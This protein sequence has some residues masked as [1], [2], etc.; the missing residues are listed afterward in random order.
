MT[1]DYESIAARLLANS[2]AEHFAGYDPFDSLNSALFRRTPLARSAFARLAWLQLGKR[3][4][5][6]LRPALLVPKVRN[7][8][9]IALFILG[10]CEDHQRTGEEAFL[11]EAVALGRWLVTHRSDPGVW[12][13]SCW[14]YPFD[15]QAR[16]FFVP[17]GKPNVIATVYIARALYRLA[18]LT[19][20]EE[21][22]RHAL[23]SASFI[24]RRL[25]VDDATRPYIAYVPGETAFVHNA[26]LW[27]AA[28]CTFAG[29]RLGN[30]NLVD[31][32]LRVAHSSAADQRAD[33][34]W[35]YGSRSHHRFI[36]GFHTGFNI[37]ALKIIC[38]ETAD[39]ELA[40]ACDA[41]YKFYIQCCFDAA[42]TAKYYAHET[43]PV[44][45]HSVAQ[46]IVT[47]IKIDCSLSGLAACRRILDRGMELLYRPSVGL[48]AY[49]RGR[50]VRNNVS[51]SR[52]TQ[53]WAYYSLALFN[54]HSAAGVTSNEG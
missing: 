15:W 32:G 51:Y 53:A 48:F 16:A 6:N 26:S 34:S 41:G 14:G 4:P 21:F 20:I 25:L 36:D 12:E 39:A 46:A 1:Y 38:E 10:L 40:R 42:A 11:S 8:K 19:G 49:Q 52:W 43:Y 27:G 45:T 22:Q 7:A 35:I 50:Y 3:L 30:S 31:L 18:E 29:R 2:R 23:S 24:R 37:E 17:A 44:D 54:R 28:W 33:G 47:I 9:G 13:G 5:I